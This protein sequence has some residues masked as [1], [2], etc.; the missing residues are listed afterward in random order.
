MQWGTVPGDRS[1]HTKSLVNE[2]NDD[3][4]SCTWKQRDA[5]IALCRHGNY[6][7][8]A[9]SDGWDA[10]DQAHSLVQYAVVAPPWIQRGT[11][12]LRSQLPRRDPNPPPPPLRRLDHQRR[13][14]RPTDR[15][16]PSPPVPPCVVAGRRRRSPPA[17]SGLLWVCAMHG[18][19]MPVGSGRRRRRQRRAC[20]RVISICYTTWSAARKR[21][22]P[23]STRCRAE[24]STWRSRYGVAQVKLSC[25][26]WTASATRTTDCAV[27]GKQPS[28]T[29]QEHTRNMSISFVT[30]FFSLVLTELWT[31]CVN[32]PA[33]LIRPL[34]SRPSQG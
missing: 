26:Q 32:A 1:S 19:S 10:S 13:Q 28:C 29:A 16:A 23:G 12:R 9:A 7:Y 14:G 27:V 17:S 8:S 4:V 30:N 24:Q 31:M 25:S 33:M 3:Q 15:A 21:R 18:R 5:S 34:V 22:P 6:V 2:D 11:G 20:L